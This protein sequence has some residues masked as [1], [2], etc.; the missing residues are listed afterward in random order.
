[1]TASG[2]RASRIQIPRRRLF[3]VLLVAI[4]LFTLVI[5]RLA[6]VQVLAS[7]TYADIGENQRVHTVKLPAGRGSIFDRNGHD[8]ALSVPQQTVWGDPQAIKDPYRTAALLAPVLDKPADDLQVLLTK[9][10]RFVYLA[11]KVTDD[12][13]ARIEALDLPGVSMYA[14]PKRF[15]PADDLL[16]GVVGAVGIDGEGLSGLEL[17]YEEVLTG[18]PGRMILERDPGGRAIPGGTRSQTTPVRGDDL[19]LTIDR[20]LQHKVESSLT[21]QIVEA[22][23]KGG[24]AAVM[25]T[26]SGEVLALANLATKGGEKGGTVI[27]AA[28][29]VALTNVY[30]PGS[31]NKLIT[32][33]GALEERLVSPTSSMVVGN[34][35]KVSDSTFKEHEDHAVEQWNT[36]EIVANSSNVG[37][38][39]IGQQLG[40][41]RLDQY[42]RAFGFGQN[43][44]LDFP[45]ESKGLMLDPKKYSG[46]SLPTIAIGQGIAVTAMQMLAA[47]NT[48]ANDGVYVAPKMLKG[49]VD[50]AGEM[51][52]TA[53]STTRQVVSTQTA[54]QMGAMLQEVVRVGTGTEAQIVGYEVAGKTGTARKPRTDGPGYEEGAY[55]SSF[56]GFVPAEDPHITGIVIL[57]QP[58]PIYGGL[59]A[60]PV[61]AD[62]GRYA[63]QEANVRPVGAPADNHGVPRTDAKAAAGVGEADTPEAPLA[64]STTTVAP[65]STSSS[66]PGRR[67][68]STSTS[69]STST[70]LR[71]K[72]STS[73]TTPDAS[74]PT[75]R[76]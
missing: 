5:G 24:I 42:M 54:R 31:V 14:E 48:I 32:I 47:Y 17:Q 72:S 68:L 74:R 8:L 28:S 62:V 57:D 6:Q 18:E 13:A 37:T 7:D 50:S 39:M 30:E 4:L 23:A 36:T 52:P 46:S 34:S 59:V 49:T 21:R 16:G 70:T 22:D 51:Q 11:R 63:L 75:G 15:L 60:A 29:N 2:A 56:A 10:G 64:G 25:D 44:G 33:S 43:T 19:V 66:V 76:D 67:Q 20:D 41:D 35:I 27:G 53:A 73:T 69:P 12:I 61:F 58:T 65:S 40:K 1:M 3:A 9:P 45:G 71:R 38:I 26:R 55:V